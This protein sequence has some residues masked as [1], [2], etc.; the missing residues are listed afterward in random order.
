VPIKNPLTI[1]RVWTVCFP[2]H[3]TRQSAWHS[4]ATPPAS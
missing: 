4:R 3:T 2:D 1:T